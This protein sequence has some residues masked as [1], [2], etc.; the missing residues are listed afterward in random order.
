MIKKQ[1]FLAW[2]FAPLKQHLIVISQFLCCENSNEFGR[3]FRQLRRHFVGSV[4][5]WLAWACDV[6]IVN[7]QMECWHRKWRPRTHR[8]RSRDHKTP[9]VDI[10]FVGVGH[11]R[12]D[13]P[14]CPVRAGTKPI[15]V[16]QWRLPRLGPATVPACHRVAVARRGRGLPWPGQLAD[17]LYR[18]GDVI[19]PERCLAFWCSP[20]HVTHTL[21]DVPPQSLVLADHVQEGA[22]RTT[23]ATSDGIKRRNG[24]DGTQLG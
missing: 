8:R 4:A 16:S 9:V 17:R 3:Q 23:A 20:A 19:K 6:S 21:V 14:R 5:V 11:C 18:A 24:Q 10:I 15:V 2:N 1:E 13:N 22:R 12:A 7:H